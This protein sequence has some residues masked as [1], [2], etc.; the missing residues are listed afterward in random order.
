MRLIDADK[1]I[2]DIYS[3]A[4]AC[5]NDEINKIL[6][7]QLETNINIINNQPT[8]YDVDKVVE[9]LEVYKY[10]LSSYQDTYTSGEIS[11]Y[12]RAINIV[13]VGGIDDRNRDK[14]NS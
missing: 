14:R 11:A 12:N 7:K 3:N 2:E 4:Y 1:L 10:T 13:K 9:Q 6:H 8:A 5:T